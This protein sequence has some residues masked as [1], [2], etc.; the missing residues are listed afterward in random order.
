M[1]EG[2]WSRNGDGLHQPVVPAP[3]AAQGADGLPKGRGRP[4]RTAPAASPGRDPPPGPAAADLAPIATPRRLIKRRVTENLVRAS[5]RIAGSGKNAREARVFQVGEIV[6]LQIS[7]IDK[8]RLDDNFV[9]CMVVEVR[10]TGLNEYKQYR[11]RCKD[12]VIDRVYSADY[13]GKMPPG[14]GPPGGRFSFVEGDNW[15][16]APKI[17][18][19]GAARKQTRAVAQNS[20]SCTCKSGC[21][22]NRCPCF[23]AGVKCTSHCHHGKACQN[24][25]E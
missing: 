11:L 8:G 15:K 16:E 14:M 19:T 6:G 5:K 17:S 13:I 12:G 18:L 20:I 4:P 9:V 22:T 25:V 24:R 1:G 23:S 10:E 7:K 2:G 3:E 21:G